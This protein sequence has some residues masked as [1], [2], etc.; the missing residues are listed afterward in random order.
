MGWIEKV[1][2]ALIVLFGTS[3][4]YA[5]CSQ[6]DLTGTWYLN[7]ITGDTL[8]AEF[9]ETDFCKVKVNSNGNVVNSSS[10]CKYRDA[11]GKAGFDIQ[12]GNLA[13]SSS[14]AITGKVKYCDG[15]FCLNLV[16][17]DARLDRGK[18]VLTLVGRLSFDPDVV[19]FFT[20]IKK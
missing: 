16:V 13:L 1:A 10:Q 19:S 18:T 12:G 11:D 6:S 3:Q 2:L 9:W 20:G 4:S 5:T 15:E 17:D 8:F 14:C 7:G